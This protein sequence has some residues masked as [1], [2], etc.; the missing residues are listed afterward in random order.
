MLEDDDMGAYWPGC[1]RWTD[2]GPVADGPFGPLPI[3]NVNEVDPDAISGLF[4]LAEED[5]TAVY[6]QWEDISYSV[7]FITKVQKRGVTSMAIYVTQLAAE[8]AGLAVGDHVEVFMRSVLREKGGRLDFGVA[9]NF[10]TEILQRSRHSMAINL[11]KET[12]RDASVDVGDM[13]EVSLI[14]VEYGK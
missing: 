7:T 14:P 10:L 1:I 2:E 4:T 6:H 8:A 13:V 11:S 5:G 12:A 3:A 9:V